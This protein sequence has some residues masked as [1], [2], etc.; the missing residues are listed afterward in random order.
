MLHSLLID[1]PANVSKE[2]AG[3]SWETLAIQWILH[4]AKPNG[5]RQKAPSRASL[6]DYLTHD[7]LAYGVANKSPA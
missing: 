3:P 1:P 6:L 5:R 2:S 7:A 4:C